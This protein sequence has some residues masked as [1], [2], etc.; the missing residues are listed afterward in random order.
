M[1]WPRVSVVIPSWNARH[2]LE[3]CLPSVLGAAYPDQ[4]VLLVDNGSTDGSAEW[5]SLHYPSVRVMRLGEN[6]GFCEGANEGLRHAT[7]L[8]VAFLNNDVEVTP[9]WLQPLI[10]SLEQDPTL[11]A[12]QPKVLD[13]HAR[14]RFEYAGAAGGYLDRYGYPFARGRMFDTL[15]EDRGQYNQPA[16]IF[17]ASG[18]ALVV[19]RALAERLGGFEPSFVLHQ[20]EIDFCW[21][22]QNLG[23]RVR[24][25]P[26]SVVYHVGGGSLAYG[27][28]RKLY[29]NH[30]N[31]LYMLYRNLPPRHLWR[32][33]LVRIGLDL[34]AA[35]LYLI[36]GRP[37]WA[38]AVGRAY[39]EAW[40]RRRELKAQRKR[41]L[42]ERV[43]WGDPPT[44]Y[45]GSIALAY[46]V[47]RRRRFADL[48][49][50]VS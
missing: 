22:L 3:R 16:D 45:P 27:D 24:A 42:A 6:R 46:Y 31:G 33:L 41:L 5:V 20:E 17:W 9:Y 13:Y 48:G 15:E 11:G 26:Q 14:G 29:Y 32:R 47:F 35:L 25:I 1:S 28:A 39:L 7:G 43:R 37:D 36:R 8:Y 21:R 2:W 40:A 49:W 4:E 19:R 44:V 10:S 18:A 30:R 23:Y 34:A 12:V 50:S 38:A